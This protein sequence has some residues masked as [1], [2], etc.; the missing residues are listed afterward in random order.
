MSGS[1]PEEWR[2]ALTVAGWTVQLVE[3]QPRPSTAM[4]TLLLLYDDY[5]YT[6][7]TRLLHVEA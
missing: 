6:S 2:A 4:L 7:S 5:Y 3:V 1:V